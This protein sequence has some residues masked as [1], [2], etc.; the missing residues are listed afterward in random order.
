MNQPAK[1]KFETSSSIK[2]QILS[3]IFRNQTYK[4]PSSYNIFFLIQNSSIHIKAI[5]TKNIKAINMF[6]NAQENIGLCIEHA[7]K[8]PNS[9]H[10]KILNK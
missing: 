3:S 4:L 6:S 5:P 10:E 8:V 9:S 1:D 2:L 7:S